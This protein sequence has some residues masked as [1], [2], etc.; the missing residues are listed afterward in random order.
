V[1]VVKD[2][3]P[4]RQPRVLGAGDPKI[5]HKDVEPFPAEIRDEAVA[6]HEV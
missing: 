4:Q 2:E 1:H 3:V 6:R 5:Q